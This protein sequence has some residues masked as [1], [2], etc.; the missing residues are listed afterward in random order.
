MISQSSNLLL[1]LPFRVGEAP[2][3]P[4][5][6]D[7]IHAWEVSIKQMLAS[8]RRQDALNVPAPSGCLVRCYVRHVK[9]LL[10]TS[11]CFQLFLEN[12]H[13]FLMAARRRKKSKTSSYVISQDSDDLKRDTDNCVAKVSPRVNVPR[14][15]AS[16]VTAH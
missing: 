3:R 14:L 11:S 8:N 4:M 6:L 9:S 2:S 10:G 13:V 1:L 5:T 15:V 7:P 12:G 16:C